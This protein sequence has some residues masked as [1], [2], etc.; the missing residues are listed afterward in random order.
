MKYSILC[1]SKFTVSGIWV[2]KHLFTNNNNILDVGMTQLLTLVRA[3]VLLMVVV[4]LSSVLVLTM[5]L[6]ISL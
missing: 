6:V 2:G 5:Q 3:V 1:E 4:F